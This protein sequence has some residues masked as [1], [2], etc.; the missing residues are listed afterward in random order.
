MVSGSTTPETSRISKPSI[1]LTRCWNF[2]TAAVVV[3]PYTP[4]SE[5]DSIRPR[6]ISLR[7]TAR[8]S[9]LDE[10]LSTFSL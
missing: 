2:L 5:P 4:S 1:W 8:M 3:V 10:F 9:F 6:K 7:W